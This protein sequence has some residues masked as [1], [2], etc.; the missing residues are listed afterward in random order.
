MKSN[1]YFYKLPIN[2]YGKNYVLE[3]ISSYLSTLTPLVVSNFQY[4]RMEFEKR[5]KVNFDQDYQLDITG[6]TKYNYLKIT[7]STSSLSPNVTA[8][9]YYFIK[10][11][12]QIAQK[13]I[14]FELSLDV[15]NTFTYNQ[16]GNKPNEYAVTERTLITREHKDRFE[17]EI[18]ESNRYTF[19]NGDVLDH[20]FEAGIDI[21]IDPQGF[22]EDLPTVN[23]GTAAATISI[24]RKSDGLLIRTISGSSIG[25]G[26][27]D[28]VTMFIRYSGQYYY[29]NEDDFKAVLMD[30]SLE[31]SAAISDGGYYA[32]SFTGFRYC[33]LG[34]TYVIHRIVDNFP[35]GISTQLF[36]NG[37]NEKVLLD[38]DGMDN[39]WYVMYAS[40]NAISGS[41]SV[42]DIKYVNPV[43]V[44]L[45][46][47]KGY[48]ISTTSS[49]EISLYA[50]SP[51]IPDWRNDEELIY[52]RI[53]TPTTLGDKY[54]IVNN[55]KYDFHNI[56]E[57][58]A[59]RKNN[60]DTFFRD[61]IVNERGVG[62]HNLGQCD[63]IIFYGI[64]SIYV[65][66]NFNEPESIY[67]G[68]GPSSYNG[69]C[70]NFESIDL[71]D[72]KLIK[73]IS[74]PYAPC[75]FLVGKT[76]FKNLPDGFRYNSD[77][78]IEL[79]TQQK[80]V[81][82]Y[83][84][85]FE[86]VNPQQNLILPYEPSKYDYRKLR[87]KIWE[88]KLF[89][90]DY[91]QPKFVYDSFSFTFLLENIDIHDYFA[92][93]TD[94][95]DLRVNYICSQN[96]QSKFLFMFPQCSYYRSNQDYDDVLC[97]ERNN[98]KA[99]F[100]NA[101]L[102]YIRSGGF[103][104]DTKK[105]SSQNA[106]NG[107]T[108]ALSIVGAIGSFASTPY[109]NVKGVVA[110]VSLTATAVT[111]IMRTIHTAQEQDRS[112]SQKL[113][114]ASMQGTSVQGSEDLDI[115]TAFSGNKAKLVE[116]KLST[117]MENA[118]NE[119]F[120]L[121]GY[122]CHRYGYFNINSRI[123]FNFVQAEI[124]LTNYTF[125]EDIAKAL[126]EKYKEGVTFMHPVAGTYDFNHQYENF[127]VSLIG[128]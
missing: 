61:V 58:K 115:L 122:A 71:S 125:N 124:E 68:S 4:Q 93:I 75:D 41:D 5:I 8:T 44:R 111:S 20:D 26:R 127:E 72:A 128:L 14:E 57:F 103:S 16:S 34:T 21:Y 106:M 116:Y 3:Y 79:Q 12:R 35:E 107:V 53:E 100:N 65:R 37:K 43:Q 15:L 121:C 120:Y 64:D 17:N 29:Y 24:Y 66:G 95:K 32:P 51:K 86:G 7:E 117:Q 85:I 110:G 23:L 48:S 55:T 42:S 105:A 36:K 109:T 52:L 84:I 31:I 6:I 60:S 76:S 27:S 33:T 62:E 25:I 73:C 83:D 80:R 119:L 39:H 101:Y 46:S 87:N 102:N 104:Y 9:Y 69:T 118:M 47:D 77:N 123:Y 54:I 11:A 92:N 45:Y 90:S 99:L 63:F 38:S 96:I 91:Y 30:I 56:I 28:N 13:T 74:F 126:Y 2:L 81:F 10:S 19:E 112:I 1:L 113:V 88:S 67:I 18:F 82:N 59:T 50:T 98:E 40:T 97:I 49:Q 78:F 22:P 70:P 94:Y 114:Q 89:H 108:T